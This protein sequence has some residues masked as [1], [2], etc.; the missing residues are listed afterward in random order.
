MKRIFILLLLLILISSQIVLADRGSIPFTPNVRIFEPGQNAVIGWNG[1][2]EILVLSTNLHASKE[3]KVLE[4]IPLPSEPEVKKAE[5]DIFKEVNFLLMNLKMN[6]FFNKAEVLRNGRSSTTRRKPAGEVTQHKEIGAHD[7]SVTQVKEADHFIAWVESYLKDHGVS[8]IKIPGPLKTVIKEYLNDDF[9]WFVFDIV[10]LGKITGTNTGIQYRFK[11]DNLYY[12][13]KITR[14]ESG[15]TDVNLAIFSSQRLTEF[16]GLNQS[17]LQSNSAHYEVNAGEIRKVS[18]EIASL[19]QIDD[20]SNQENFHLYDWKIRGQLSSFKDDLLVR[21][22]PEESREIT[23]MGTKFINCMSDHNYPF[24]TDKPVKT[25]T[26]IINEQMGSRMYPWMAAT[27][28]NSVLFNA[29]TGE[30]IR[31]YNKMLN[32][33]LSITGY[34][35]VG[36]IQMKNPFDRQEKIIEFK[37]AFYVSNIVGWD[38]VYGDSTNEEGEVISSDIHFWVPKHK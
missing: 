34:P 37:N 27:I 28:N 3:T 17:N 35:G 5:E 23:F 13:L 38:Y 6:E 19:F 32:K 30:L 15:E 22:A 16:N 1:T 24:K 29:H 2:E 25:I 7:I 21:K 31:N 12:P 33:K 18:S 10:E 4:V 8:K 20:S 26:G 14:A 36:R 11:S 9:S